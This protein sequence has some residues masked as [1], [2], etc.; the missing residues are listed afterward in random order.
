ML[1]FWY[2]VN[3]K[4]WMGTPPSPR[5]TVSY[6]VKGLT[7]YGLPMT[8]IAL[9]MLKLHFFHI[10]LV[11]KSVICQF[12]QNERSQLPWTY[13]TY[14]F[15]RLPVR[16]KIRVMDDFLLGG[17]TL[18]DLSFLTMTKSVCTH[19]VSPGGGIFFLWFRRRSDF[20]GNL[21]R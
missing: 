7:M 8:L 2:F 19:A 15:P 3:L 10:I 1:F 4:S 9:D 21:L 20:Q 12:N 13:K 16:K 11:L 18:K 17:G 5:C 6:I 14:L